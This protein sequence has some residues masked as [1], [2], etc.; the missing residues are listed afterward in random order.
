MKLYNTRSREVE[1]VQPHTPGF[2]R[3]Y[4]CRP[5]VYST[6]HI[7]NFRSFLV[8][9]LIRRVLED[10]GYSVRHVMNITDVGHMTADDVDKIQAAAD[11][12]GSTPEEIA[13][14]HE[15]EFLWCM[16]AL[17]CRMPHVLPRASEFVPGMLRTVGRLLKNGHAYISNG[18]VY[19]TSSPSMASAGLRAHFPITANT[20]SQL[21]VSRRSSRLDMARCLA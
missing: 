4:T 3:M 21:G 7:G 13:R 5:T 10:Q 18:S 12:R 1:T 11:K 6:P 2:V 16:R 14:Y 15:E 20:R 19:F 9:D 8:A 17:R